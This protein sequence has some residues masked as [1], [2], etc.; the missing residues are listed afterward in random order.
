[1]ALGEARS[2][3]S[4][5]DACQMGRITRTGEWL[6]MNPY[7]VNGKEVG[8]KEWGDSLFLSYGI[9]PSNSTYHCNVTEYKD[10]LWNKSSI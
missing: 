9:N 5:E 10:I 8:T 2:A 7:S 1:M 6:L 4:T 3:A